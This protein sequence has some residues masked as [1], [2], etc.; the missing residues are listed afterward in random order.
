MKKY[1]AIDIGT[2]SL[3]L[4]LAQIRGN[5]FTYRKKE[6]APTRIG[7][8]VDEEGYISPEGMARNLKALELFV[9]KAR[10]YGAGKIMAIGT[11][12]LRDAKN[13]EDFVKKAHDRLGI[14]IKI[15]SG[16]EEAQLGYRGVCLALK[17]A[18]R[19]LLV[20]IGGGSTEFIL[21]QAGQLQEAYSEDIGAVRITERVGEDYERLYSL[22]ENNM[23]ARLG[24]LKDKRI[25]EVIAIGGTINRLAAIDQ[26]LETYDQDKIHNYC[27]TLASIRTIKKRL[28]GMTLE[29][30]KQVKGLQ[31]E[32]ADIIIG[33]I[34]ILLCIMEG[35]SIKKIRI[36]EYDGLEGIIYDQVK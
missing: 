29:E 4:L 30:R 21:G 20:D 5:K 15:L 14:K 34:A 1:A 26:E 25:E 17:E 13:A 22:V 3:R 35:L 8:S 27:L 7:E 11:S 33:G 23:G 32:R 12:G 6:L 10:D 31:A 16:Q 18:G 36:S 19:V 2:N 28:S 9:N 24:Q